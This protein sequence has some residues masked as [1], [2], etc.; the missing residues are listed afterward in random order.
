MPNPKR[1][2]TLCHTRPFSLQIAILGLVILCS[3]DRDNSTQPNTD[4]NFPIHQAEPAWSHGDMLLYRDRAVVCVMPD[5]AHTTDNSKA[6]IWV[7]NV[8]TMGRTRI[9]PSGSTPEWSPHD[10]S[11]AFTLNG[12]IA[13]SSLINPVPV[14]ITSGGRNYFPRWSPTRGTIAF[15]SDYQSPTGANTIWLVESNGSNLRRVSDSLRGT[16]GELRMPDWSPDGQKL[17]HIR[18]PGVSTSEIFV[19]NADGTNPVRLTSN[20]FQEETPRFSPDGTRIAF[21]RWDGRGG[22]QIW[23]MNADGSDEVQLTADGGSWP[24]W[25]PDGNQIA[26]VRVDPSNKDAG[27]IWKLVLSGGGQQ[28]TTKWP[29]ECP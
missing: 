10:D 13:I 8:A 6:G 3:C 25:S 20:L 27:L 7:L 15:D 19:M 18:Y 2:R 21:S 12:Q 22:T 26:F 14:L 29:T 16:N 28:L 17:L 1:Q 11:I 24:T 9:L 5:G 4:V 23:V